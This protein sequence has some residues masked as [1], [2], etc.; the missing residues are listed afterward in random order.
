MHTRSGVGTEEQNT[1]LL[2]CNTNLQRRSHSSLRP[3]VKKMGLMM[4]YNIFDI[5]I[6]WWETP[7]IQ[8]RHR[9]LLISTDL[10][11]AFSV[12]SASSSYSLPETSYITHLQTRPICRK[13]R[14]RVF[15]SPQSPSPTLNPPHIKPISNFIA[16]LPLTMIKPGD[17][18]SSCYNRPRHINLIIS[19]RLFH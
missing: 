1:D 17:N 8:Q 2:D 18:E 13:I 12:P 10:S 4:L 14:G 16:P 9:P 6:V 15:L 19:K 3:V 7:E 5:I 11:A